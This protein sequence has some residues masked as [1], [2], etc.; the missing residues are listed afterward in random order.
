MNRKLTANITISKNIIPSGVHKYSKK[1]KVLSV[2]DK[3]AKIILAIIIDTKTTVQKF[4]TYTKK[5]GMNLNIWETLRFE[6]WR[7]KEYNEKLFWVTIR[8]T[9]SVYGIYKISLSPY[10]L[11]N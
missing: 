3:A 11:D 2:L 5:K 6:N 7:L 10:N 1:F 8:I 9:K 4:F